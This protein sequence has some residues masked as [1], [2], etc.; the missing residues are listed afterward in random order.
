MPWSQLRK[1]KWFDNEDHAV[2]YIHELYNKAVTY[3]CE[4]FSLYE[5]TG[6]VSENHAEHSCYPYI[7]ISISHDDLFVDPSFAYGVI[8]E[9][10]HYG[11]TVTAPALYDSYFREQIKLLLDR[12]GVSIVVGYS[13]SR[14][15]LPFVIEHSHAQFDVDELMRLQ[16]KF[17]LPDLKRIDDSYA[18][19]TFSSNGYRPLAL[20]TGERVDFSLQRLH[21][22]TG[23]AP[24]HFQKFVLL[25]NY[26]RYI[27]EFINQ[28]STEVEHHKNENWELIGPGSTVLASHKQRT[29][30]MPKSLPQMPAYHFKKDGNNGITI[31][32][33]GVGPSNAKTITDHLA[34]LRPHCW[35]MLGHCAG[36]R[37]SQTLGDYVLA[38]GYVREDHVLDDDLPKWVPIP[39]IAEIQ[40]ALQQSVL[41]IFGKGEGELK[42]AIR[43]GTVHTTDNRNWELQS[44]ALYERFRQSRA[45]AVDMESATIAANGFRFRVPY[46]T[47][48]CVSDKPIHG[49]IKLQAMANEFYRSRV[50]HHL[51]VGLQAM[52]ILQ[53][54]DPQR[55]HSRKLRGFDE[56]PFR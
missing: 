19:A 2:D 47:L 15:P 18:N 33:I 26:Q 9:P 27:D 3:I 40:Q 6:T 46:G 23:T 4:N 30:E 29:M 11:T 22:Y 52:E 35:I 53:K 13:N 54:M 7:G 34:V 20:F 43:T 45:I 32:N 24:H 44:T 38:D 39:P 56:C 17:V 5:Q 50:N 36:L 37:A 51:H 31:I 12:H 41:H 49:V 28:V 48:L 25:T 55:L 10:G 14:I 21:H 8:N 1:A 16:S 42:S